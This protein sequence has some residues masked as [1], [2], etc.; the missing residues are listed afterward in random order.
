MTAVISTICAVPP[1]T[2]ITCGSRRFGE[3]ALA[4]AKPA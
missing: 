2:N 1:R 3:I 4:W